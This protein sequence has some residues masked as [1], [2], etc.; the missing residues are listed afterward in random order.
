MVIRLVLLVG[1]CV[2]PSSPINYCWSNDVLCVKEVGE[3]VASHSERW[4][5]DIREDYIEN[6]LKRKVNAVGGAWSLSNAAIT[7]LENCRRGL[8]MVSNKR[9]DP[10][11]LTITLNVNWPSV[12]ISADVS[13]KNTGVN[14]KVDVTTTKLDGEMVFKYDLRTKPEDG[15]VTVSYSNRN[16]LDAYPTFST[17]ITNA[18]MWESSIDLITEL[19]GVWNAYLY[20]LQVQMVNKIYSEVR[21]E[22]NKKK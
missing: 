15:P 19:N 7:G 2:A 17:S 12:N 16:P 18:N 22:L 10:L 9:A 6:P 3:E 13:H 8:V 20:D 1:F 4:L 11:L 5:K 14:G 21:K